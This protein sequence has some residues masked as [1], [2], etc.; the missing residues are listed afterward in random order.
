MAEVSSSVVR[1]ARSSALGIW[2]RRLAFYAAL[3]LLWQVIVNMNI[4]PSYALPGPVDVFNSL[5]N[6]IASG[7]FIQAAL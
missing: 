2:A 3:L 1:T 5:A 4:W 7:Q 6:G